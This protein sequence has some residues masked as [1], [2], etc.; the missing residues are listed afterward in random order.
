MAEDN[1]N[2]ESLP[3]NATGGSLF[4]FTVASNFKAAESNFR[5]QGLRL[6][7]D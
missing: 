5:L 2:F 3:L 7:D 6:A 1:G 4:L